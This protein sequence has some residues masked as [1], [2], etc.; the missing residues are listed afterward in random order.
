M[1]VSQVSDQQLVDNSVENGRRSKSPKGSVKVE[2]DKGWLRLGFTHAGRRRTFALGL[3]DGKLNQKMAEAK[4]QQIEL[5]ILSGNFDPSLI[6]YKPE[7][8]SSQ[9]QISSLTVTG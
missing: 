4:A 3:P 1:K 5:D 8:Q 6:K 9:S 7:K 2:N